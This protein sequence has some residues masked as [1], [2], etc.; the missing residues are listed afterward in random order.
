MQIITALA[1]DSKTVD[2]GTAVASLPA[3][4]PTNG[5]T[6]VVS[7]AEAKALG[8]MGAS[9]QVDGYIGFASGNLF[10]YNNSDG[11]TAGN[12][13]FSSTANIFDYDK[14]D[15]ITAGQYDFFGTV[16]HEITEIMGRSM[17]VGGN[18]SGTPNCYAPLDLFHYSGNGVRTFSGSTPGYFSIDGGVTSLNAFN[19]TN[20]GDYGD[21]AA[22]AT[23]D[24]FL[25]FSSPGVINA[26]SQTDLREMDALG[27]DRAAIQKPDLVVSKFTVTGNSFSFHIDNIGIGGASASSAGIYYGTSSGLGTLV[28]TVSIPSIKAGLTDV[29]TGTFA[30]P[31]IAL[32]VTYFVRVVADY[33]KTVTES[34]EVNNISSSVALI[35][36]TS[37]ANTLTGTSGNDVIFGRGGNDVLTG[38]LGADQFVFDTAPKAG[39]VT[40]IKDFSIGQGDKIGLDHSIFLALTPQANVGA[41]LAAADFVSNTTGVAQSAADHIIYN[42]TTGALYYDTDG[43]GGAAAI[44]FAAVVG[45]PALSVNDFMLV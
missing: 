41:P 14:S 32:P 25:A 11:I 13:G 35:Y 27:W 3:N 23:N 31:K 19:T 6:L 30:L 20:G 16:V 43:V 9:S 22:S 45:H 7:T 39:L 15:G 5:G 33:N 28:G 40:S 37:G 18:I 21:W 24:S 38:G 10:D 2:D 26:V 44:K 42:T 1:N 8:L 29:E 36:G 4:D 12:V 34:S 17:W